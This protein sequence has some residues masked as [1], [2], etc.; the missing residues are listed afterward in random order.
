MV[1][2]LIVKMLRKVFSLW[3]TKEI[4]F[5]TVMVA[6]WPVLGFFSWGFKVLFSDAFIPLFYFLLWLNA[7]IASPQQTFFSVFLGHMLFDLFFAFNP[8]FIF[9]WLASAFSAFFLS[10]CKNFFYLSFLVAFFL[11]LFYILAFII[12]SFFYFGSNFYQYFVI[13]PRL[14]FTLLFIN[15]FFALFFYW[16]FLKNH[17]LKQIIFFY[18]LN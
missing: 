5:A 7:L 2:P 3:T 11:P 17:Q 15:P 4:V 8:F 14:T 18:H 12:I 13:F 16:L 1:P 9:V 6:A 10:C